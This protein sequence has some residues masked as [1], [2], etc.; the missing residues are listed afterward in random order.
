MTRRPVDRRPVLVENDF[1]L[2]GLLQRLSGIIVFDDNGTS[3]FFLKTTEK[4]SMGLEELQILSSIPYRSLTS[5]YRSWSVGHTKTRCKQTTWF[6]WVFGLVGIHLPL[7][8]VIRGVLKPPGLEG[9][10]I[11]PMKVK[12]T[13]CTSC[14]QGV[15]NGQP[16]TAYSSPLDTHWKR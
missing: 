2:T 5:F 12:T 3:K 16:Y 13:Y 10:G 1:I 4:H 9:P 11:Y 14:F 8:G 7:R 15:T 6:Y